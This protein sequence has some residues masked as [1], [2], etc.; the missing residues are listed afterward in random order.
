MA[1]DPTL[2][3]DL[4]RV[5]AELLDMEKALC[6]G[7]LS[8]FVKSAWGIIE[9]GT[10]LHWN[11]HVATICGYL[12][13]FYEGK[14]PNNRLIINVPPGCLKSILVSV[15]Y[16]AWLWIKDPTKR[17]L[18]ISNEQGLATRDSLRMK[19]IIASQWFQR[20]WPLAL[21]ADQNE[22]TLYANEKRGFRQA[23]GIT[24][25]VTGKRGDCF[26]SY[27]KIKTES[28]L[29]KIVDIG[30][31]DLV[32]S[33]N[34]TTQEKELKPVT[35]TIHKAN[36]QVIALQLSNGS[37][38]HCTPDH[39]IWTIESGYVSAANLFV[40]S[41]EIV[42]MPGAKAFFAS[43]KP[44]IAHGIHTLKT[45]DG[46]PLYVVG[47]YMASHDEDV[48]C[49]SVKDNHNMYAYDETI[50]NGVLLSNCV[51]VD[52]PV[53]AKQAFSDVIRK[54]ANDTFDQSITTRIND[55]ETSGFILIMQRLHHEDLTGH[56]LKKT[57]KK[58]TNLVIP[59]CFKDYPTFDAGKDIGR[60]EL[61]D[62]RTQ[63]G[64]LMF[65]KRFTRATIGSL[66]EDLGD[67]GF[68]GQ[69]QQM[70]TPLGGGIIKEN[71]WRIWSSDINLPM[72][73]HIFHSYDT[74]FTDKH[75]KEAAFSAMTRWGIFWHEERER[76][77]IMCLGRWFDRVGYDELRAKVKEF[78]KKYN[79][80][81][82]LVEKKSTGI[83]L[84]QDLK[85]ASPGRVRSYNPG[86]G[87]DK[88]SRGHSVSPMF[89]SGIVYIPDR[90]WALG[91]AEKKITGLVEYISMFPAGSPPC[92]DLFDSCTAA[93]I[94]MRSNNW[95]GD[96][97]DD[98]EI[99]YEEPRRSEEF[100][101]DNRDNKKERRF[102]S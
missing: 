21:Q 35:H 97:D 5:E 24:S 83:S 3:A 55:P 63:K 42:N 10:K 77:C 85:H 82:N 27:V 95:V 22:K 47:R 36:K 54:A 67:Y 17:V 31:G 43:Y 40:M 33:F 9:P 94:Y 2:I 58:W 70:P 89:Q 68:A 60:P 34:Q 6:E 25:G 71:W 91:S 49:L 102:Y 11:W 66:K 20:N 44:I 87:E 79:P 16:P 69:M 92:A 90:P 48:Y 50:I 64:E 18:T 56:L 37:E 74:A 80:D 38:L 57:E 75:I 96:H 51:I 12:E 52:D 28:G 4:L 101:E 73:Q 32:W 62:P 93:L 13:E 72:M 65:P 100:I 98:K 15:M 61:N 26:P 8:E 78:D 81:M 88:V 76:Y 14:I 46:S 99:P 86:K 45:W 30:V 39:K 23:L 53:D 7:S 59:M 19:Q 41:P 29:K 84:I 1:N